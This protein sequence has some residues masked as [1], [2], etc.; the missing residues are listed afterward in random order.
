[1]NNQIT[2]TKILAVYARIEKVR[3]LGEIVRSET[4]RRDYGVERMAIWETL[5]IMLGH[6]DL[7]QTVDHVTALAKREEEKKAQFETESA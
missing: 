4:L 2:V 6:D 1:M 7:M 3:R 5:Q